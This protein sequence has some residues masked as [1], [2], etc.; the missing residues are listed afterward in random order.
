MASGYFK[1]EVQRRV[2]KSSLDS[3]T[4]KLSKYMDQIILSILRIA[5]N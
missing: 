3:L 2:E 1:D 5:P 4:A